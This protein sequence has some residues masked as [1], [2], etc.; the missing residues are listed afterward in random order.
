[1]KFRSYFKACIPMVFILTATV[2]ANEE[3]MVMETEAG[4]QFPMKKSVGEM[5]MELLGCK[6]YEYWTF[7]LYSIGLYSTEKTSNPR[8]LLSENVGKKLVIRYHRSIDRDKIIKATQKNVENNPDVNY[9]AIMRDFDEL[10]ACY[11]SVEDGDQYEIIYTPGKGSEINFNGKPACSFDNPEFSKALFSIWI[12]EHSIDDDL[13][14]ALR[15]E[16]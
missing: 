9:S 1:M 14:E 8:E 2:Q 7:D 10:Y 6:L 15:G 5:E 3:E 11:T 13:S 4:V 16:D 12:S